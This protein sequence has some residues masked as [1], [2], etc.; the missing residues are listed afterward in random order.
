MGLIGAAF[1][2]GF[3][4]GPAFSAVLGSMG[5]HSCPFYAAA[6]LSLANAAFALTRLPE[7]RVPGDSPSAERR[8]FPLA[9]L[10]PGPLALV[11]GI[12]FLS[13]FAMGGMENTLGL[14]VAQEPHLAFSD[15]QF[16]LLVAFVGVV[17]VLTQGFVLKRLAA[18]L[19]EMA[20]VI[21]GAFTMI[22]GL[23]LIG[24][25]PG[26][27]TLYGLMGL[28]GFG[29][30][31]LNPS[32]ASLASMLASESERGEVLGMG[33]AMSAMGRILGPFFGGLLYEHVGHKAPYAMSGGAMVLC[34]LLALALPRRG[35]ASEPRDAVP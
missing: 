12:W 30:G 23:G 34:F 1:G 8:R 32:V 16:A 24:W 19:G 14:F 29:N 35:V 3:I 17:I 6:A 7:S 26:S 22:F 28:T 13:T 27:G 21:G 20:L 5:G 9:S 31:L 10:R 18:R 25:T 33:Q 2:L 11:L 15:R 4:L